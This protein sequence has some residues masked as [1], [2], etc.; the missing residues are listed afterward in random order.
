MHK[1]L[2][3]PDKVGFMSNSHIWL[4]LDDLDNMKLA[5]LAHQ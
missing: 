3:V 2:F 5:F 1:D 4:K